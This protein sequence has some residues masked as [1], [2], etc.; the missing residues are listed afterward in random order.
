MGGMAIMFN[1]IIMVL[2]EDFFFRCQYGICFRN[3]EIGNWYLE[4]LD[5]VEF[6]FV[7]VNDFWI[8][9]YVCKYL[10]MLLFYQVWCH[11]IGMLV[12]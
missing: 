2:V 9:Y 11:V 6:S 5:N 4:L 10:V 3:L 12:S 7:W 1:N 8:F